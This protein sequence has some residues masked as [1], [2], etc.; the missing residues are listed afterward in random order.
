[1]NIL[2]VTCARY[3]T[4]KAYGVTVGNTMKSLTKAAISNSVITWGRPMHDNYG[5]DIKSIANRPLRV[6]F[7]LYNSNI[8]IVAKLS[9]IVN[10]VIFS[11]YFAKPWR[12][13]PDDSIFWTREPL[14]LIVRSILHPRSRFLIDLHHSI[15]ILN[16]YVIRF[17]GRNN[18]LQILVLNDELESKYATFFAGKNF[19]NL[20]MGVPASFMGLNRKRENDDFVIGYLGKG[21]SNGHDNELSEIVYVAKKLEHIPN[22]KFKF[23]GLEVKYRE[24]LCQLIVKLGIGP[25]K[26]IFV[27]HLQHSEIPQELLKFDA[28]IVPYPESFYNSERFPIKILEYAAIG[29]PIIASDTKS[30][31]NL[32]D[33]SFATF[34]QKGNQLE[35]S[36]SIVGL[37]R[38]PF[39]YGAMAEKARA[40]SLKFTYDERVGK[41]LDSLSRNSWNEEKNREKDL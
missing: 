15:G 16:K 32:L 4:E 9:Y 34:Y 7:K 17:L 11:V 35:L 37:L 10:Q 36:N 5:N 33:A 39:K 41:L 12:K 14:T 38:D 29:I 2:F 3:P 22:L 24:K 21:F 25:N 40:F 30:N 8:K 19:I 18:G 31:R 1:M 26:I 23:V 28:G 27:D 20:P 13:Y 6:P